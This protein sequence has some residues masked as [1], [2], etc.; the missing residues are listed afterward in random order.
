MLAAQLLLLPR[1]ILDESQLVLLQDLTSE[2]LH[3]E[4]IKSPGRQGLGEDLVHHGGCLG[5]RFSERSYRASQGLWVLLSRLPVE[6]VTV[7]SAGALLGE[8][9]RWQDVG[10]VGDV[11]A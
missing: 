2:E 11:D 9:V 7:G 1:E 10:V 5:D 3:V 8:G 4:A 6:G